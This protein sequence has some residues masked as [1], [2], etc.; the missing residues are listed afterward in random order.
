MRRTKIV[1]TLGP[2]SSSPEV[3]RRLI[4]AGMDVARL[5]F[6]HGDHE[7]HAR[8]IANVRAIS[9]ELDTP[10]TIL[11][12][13]QG[14]KIRVGTLPGGEMTL[15]P[16]SLITM[17][18]EADFTGQADAI[19]LDY[20]EVADDARAGVQVLLADGLFELEIVEVAGRELRCRVIEGGMLKSR[21][22]V[23][24]PNLNLHLPSLTE[25]DRLDLEFGIKHEVDW[26]SLSFVRTAADVRT[27]KD[28]LAAKGVSKPVIAKIEKPQAV[29]NLEEILQEVSGVMVARGDLGVEVSPEKVPMLQK[30][31]IERCNRTGLPVITATQML[32][33]MI[34][35]SRPTRA[36]ASDVANAIIDG[37]DAVMLSGESAIGAFPV[38]AVEMMARIATEVEAAI[39]FKTYP[40]SDPTDAHALSE[41]A[42]AVAKVVALR[43]LVV[44]TTSGYT[45]R[46][47][48][49][50]RSK[51]PLFAIT[52]DARVYHLLNLFWGIRPLLVEGTPETFEGLVAQAESALR[53]RKLVASDDKILVIGG[54]PAGQ[55]RGSNFIKLHL[56]R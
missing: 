41:A 6:S 53:D 49:S 8:N 39:E 55:P 14:P 27:L 36:E 9:K 3:I 23:N 32:E 19:P 44:R 12:D 22:G 4:Q 7:E 25:K 45:A 20:A 43:A 47:V 24:F 30:H 11:Q 1:V 50:E 34:H 10:V 5:N 37:T 21:K 2:A 26:V 13:L 42:T 28:L 54:V 51:A 29:E 17:M 35:D 18:P 38:R 33:S 52:T 31:I 46:L 40:A 16:G 15:T 56:V 48:A